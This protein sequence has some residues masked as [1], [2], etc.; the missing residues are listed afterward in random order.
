MKRSIIAAATIAS[1][2]LTGCTVNINTGTSE[3]TTEPTTATSETTEEPTTT[4]TSE[5][6]ESSE[7]TPAFTVHEVSV[8]DLYSNT[9][10]DFAGD[11]TAKAPKIIVDGVEQTAVN[12]YISTS[13]AQNHPLNFNSEVKMYEGELTDYCWGSNGK[14]LSVIIIISYLSEDGNT[15]E[16]YN[17]DLDT[18]ELINN[19]KVLSTFNTSEDVF[20]SQVATEY[21]N[22]WASE[23]WL[24]GS[25]AM[26]DQSIAE[27]S[28]TS[29]TA[30][31]LPDGH[32]GAVGM[33]HVPSQIQDCLKI[34]D[35][36]EGGLY[37]FK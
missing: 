29:T 13:L 27:I 25:D 5:T 1:I 12:S 26:R 3:E 30:V 35:L 15:Y 22:W 32:L 2:L 21:T 36:T 11:Y 10:S 18:M 14:V 9:Y 24:I 7:T 34:F 31:V 4:T 37:S 19:D 17:Y 33:V 28:S 6:T 16:V 23:S 20:E 8:E